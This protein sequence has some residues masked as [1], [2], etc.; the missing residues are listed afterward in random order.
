MP[1]IN[2]PCDTCGSK[3]YPVYERY[4]VNSGNS[5]KL[6]RHEVTGQL[7]SADI[8][9]HCTKCKNNMDDKELR[10]THCMDSGIKL[11]SK[12]GWIK[13]SERLPS[14]N[15]QYLTY[16]KDNKVDLQYFFPFDNSFAE[17]NVTHWQPLP[18]PPE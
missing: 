1:M 8:T 4:L 17:Q 10:K 11:Q 16:S 9:Y 18:S 14:D 3:E 7:I 15:N 6:K 2:R 5:V 12:N 13:C